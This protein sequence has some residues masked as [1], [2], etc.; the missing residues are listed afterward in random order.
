VH[1]VLGAHGGGVDDA[2]AGGPV[3]VVR[4]AEGRAVGVGDLLVGGDVLAA[5]GLDP[6]AL[7]ADT[8][9]GRPRDSA[10]GEYATTIALRTTGVSARELAAALRRRSEVAGAEVAGPGFVNLWLTAA[11][12]AAIVAEALHD[13]PD[14]SRMRAATG[15]V[16][17]PDD[18]LAAV[19]MDAARFAVLRGTT[20]DVALLARRVPENPAF[21]VQYAHARLVGLARNAADLGVALGPDRGVL[22]HPDEIELVRCL[23]GFPAVVRTGVPHRLA[24]HLEA[25]ADAVLDVNDSCAVL[26]KGDEEVTDLHRARLAMVVAARRVLA[27]GLGLLGVGAPERI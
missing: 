9:T 13:V 16:S 15:K 23:A 17:V 22:S 24:R 7:P 19:G 10:Q 4:A 12:R 3:A 6:A 1:E 14:G 5:R 25:L 18:L 21:R 2:V 27:N 8:G 26:P 11:G 20:P